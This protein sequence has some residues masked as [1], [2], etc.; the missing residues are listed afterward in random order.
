MHVHKA[1]TECSNAQYAG[2]LCP[3]LC[4]KLSTPPGD[5][6]VAGADTFLPTPGC[7]TAGTAGSG[8]LPLLMRLLLLLPGAVLPALLL[9]LLLLLP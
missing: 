2:R 9:P 1:H 3:H 8:L 7:S 6:P 5:T 4:R